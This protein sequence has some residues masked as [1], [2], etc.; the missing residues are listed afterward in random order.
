MNFIQLHTNA[1]Y[2]NISSKFNFQGNWVQG[3][4]AVFRKK[5]KQKKKKKKKTVI[6]LV[7]TFV[8][9]F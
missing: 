5:K 2:D 3:Q 8:D 7:P 6:A 1:G 9:G 4:G